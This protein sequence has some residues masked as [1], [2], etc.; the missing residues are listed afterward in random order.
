MELAIRKWNF[1]MKK[2]RG[3]AYPTIILRVLLLLVGCTT[4]K[5]YSQFECS[6]YKTS[7]NDGFQLG[8]HCYPGPENGNCSCESWFEIQHHNS[9]ECFCQGFN[10]GRE[11]R[12]NKYPDNQ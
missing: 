11:K 12:K 2:I 10:D 1:R 8:S 9:D 5:D 4:K 3:L 6:A 7:Y